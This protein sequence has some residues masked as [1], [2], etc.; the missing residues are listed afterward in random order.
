VLNRVRQLLD[1]WLLIAQ[2]VSP[3]AQLEY[4]V[5]EQ[6]SNK[7]LLRDFLDPELARQPPIFRKFRANRSMRDVEHSVELT[8]KPLQTWG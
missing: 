5:E 6:A 7:R 2:Q 4:Q 1:D 3:N 8:V